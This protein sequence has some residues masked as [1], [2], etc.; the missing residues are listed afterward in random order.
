[1]KFRFLVVAALLTCVT[2]TYAQVR[3]FDVNLEGDLVSKLPADTRLVFT[4]RSLQVRDRPTCDLSQLPITLPYEKFKD[5]S[6]R[7]FFS[8]KSTQARF[9]VELSRD[10]FD[11]LRPIRIRLDVPVPHITP[12]FG[13]G[14]SF[15]Y[16]PR[17][18]KRMKYIDLPCWNKERDSLGPTMP[19]NMKIVSLS[20]GSF[21][22]NKEM[23]PGCMGAKWFADV[24]RDLKLED[25]T[26]YRITATYD[27]G[28]LF[29][30]VTTTRDFTYHASLHGK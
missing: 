18:T 14:R 17:I 12:L 15:R 6:C 11:T 5:H 22:Y 28:G 7:V 20:D 16:I 1:M 29:P 19:P 26:T 4:N 10:L 27:S 30:R 21:L 25:G 3:G 2:N 13:L 8:S 9:S 23:G 24:N